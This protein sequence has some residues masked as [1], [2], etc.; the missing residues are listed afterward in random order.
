MVEA[1]PYHMFL[2]LKHQKFEVF[3]FSRS[4]VG[5][6]YRLT[7]ELPAEERYNLIRQFEE[8]SFK[9]SRRRF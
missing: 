7:K 6:C 5:E 1:K 4:V 8:R 9:H 2:Q 3:Q